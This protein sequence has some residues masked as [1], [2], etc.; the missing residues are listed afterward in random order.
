MA[1]LDVLQLFIL[2]AVLRLH[3]RGHAAPNFELAWTEYAK[4]GGMQ[5]AD[6]YGRAASARAFQR[7]L[8]A[9]LLAATHARCARGLSRVRMC[10]HMRTCQP[11]LAL[12]A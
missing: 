3:R 2:T 12:S 7:L 1:G 5:H 8:D 10:M 4:T 9:G 6:N 11:C